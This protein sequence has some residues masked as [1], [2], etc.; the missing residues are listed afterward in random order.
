MS[1]MYMEKAKQSDSHYCRS[2]S[3]AQIPLDLLGSLLVNE[4]LGTLSVVTDQVLLQLLLSLPSYA[5]NIQN[6]PL[7]LK[8]CLSCCKAWWEIILKAAEKEK[9]AKI[10]KVHFL[11]AEFSAG[12]LTLGIWFQQ[13]FLLDHV[14]PSIG[15]VL[16]EN[17]ILKLNWSNL[18]RTDNIADLD[19]RY[20]CQIWA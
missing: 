7:L 2:Y 10:V 5:P 18:K 17:W 6:V 3:F 14:V 20:G 1:T 11:P 19:A 12:F 9:S 8:H 13:E 15:R 16:K 4:I